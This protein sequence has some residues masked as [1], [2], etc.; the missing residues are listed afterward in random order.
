L[1]VVAADFDGRNGRD[2]LMANA[3]RGVSLL[4]NRGQGRFRRVLDFE[5]GRGAVDVG[6]ADF[7]MDGRPDVAMALRAAN[8]V[9]VR[10]GREGTRFHDEEYLRMGP[11]QRSITV[12]DV[13]GDGEADLLVTVGREVDALAVR[14]GEGHGSFGRLVRYPVADDPRAAV[15]ADFDRDG[16]RDVAVASG[17]A[18]SVV[19]LRGRGGGELRPSS[20][21]AAAAAG[22]ATDL[23]AGLFDRDA[24][25]DLAVATGSGDSVAVHLG[26]R[27]GFRAPVEYPAGTNAQA[28][29]AKELNG[30]RRMDLAVAAA[31]DDEVNLFLGRSDGVFVPGR[32]VP[33]VGDRPRALILADLRR[34]GVFGVPDLAVPSAGDGLAS[35]LF[36][37]PLKPGFCPGI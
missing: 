29:V 1:G 5:A 17:T 22:A 33:G 16:R 7:N 8:Y 12:A 31:G 19:V 25:R 36:N 35:V 23:D 9:S 2:L 6:T 37:Q 4:R 13:N 11:A 20:Q 27:K 10:L 26:K 15:V 24:R 3:E 28:V 21:F 18:N 14:L 30:S 34:D 32:E